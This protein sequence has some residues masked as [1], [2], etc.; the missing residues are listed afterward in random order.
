M[1]KAVL[2]LELLHQPTHFCIKTD[3]CNKAHA[4]GFDP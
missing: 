4:G 2:Q 1:G 3:Y